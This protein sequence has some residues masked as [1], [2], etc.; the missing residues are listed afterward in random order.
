MMMVMMM[1]WT[2]V[3]V[4]TT[5]TM[6][7]KEQTQAVAEKAGSSGHPASMQVAVR[8]RGYEQALLITDAMR[9]T[10]MPDGEYYLGE[11]KTFVKNGAARLEDGTLAGS[12]LTMADAV[13]NMVKLVGLPLHQAVAMAS[14]HPARKHRLD[15][16]KGAIAAGMDADLVLLDKDLRVTETIVEGEIVYT[17]R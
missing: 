15:G 8:A 3:M 11:L 9:A 6:M 2:I 17:T 1:L 16:R 7:M 4:T 12:V 5:T 10:G 14:L 13:R